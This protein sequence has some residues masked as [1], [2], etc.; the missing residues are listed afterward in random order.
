MRVTLYLCCVVAGLLFSGCGK[1]SSTP[2]P[3]NV[4]SGNPVT[5]PV[6]YLGAVAKAKKSI[7]QTVDTVGL[8]QAI[9][10]F[11]GQ[12]GR[13]PKS[14]SELVEQKYISSVPPAPAGMK[15]DY[16]PTTGQ[17]KVVPQ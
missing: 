15:Y 12:E 7:E 14:L 13:N 16:N 10:M 11:Q 2:Q 6:D 8:T 9:Q 4:S 3:T 1:K 17:V 5:A